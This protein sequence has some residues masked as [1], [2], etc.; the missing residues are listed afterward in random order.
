MIKPLLLRGFWEGEQ[1]P[2]VGV[3]HNMIDFF[4]ASSRKNKRSEY[5]EKVPLLKAI[6]G[7]NEEQEHLAFW[8][9]Y[10]RPCVSDVKGVL[11]KYD[12]PQN[13]FGV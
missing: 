5:Y 8:H 6:L 9:N 2:D 11:R 1:G 4:G 7:G 3:Q 10:D 12:T 13:E